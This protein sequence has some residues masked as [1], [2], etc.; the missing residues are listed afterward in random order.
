MPALLLSDGQIH[1]CPE[2]APRRECC[3]GD[4]VPFG[5]VGVCVAAN[6]HFLALLAVGVET[7]AVALGHQHHPGRGPCHGCV[8]RAF[9]RQPE[10]AEE[11]PQVLDEEIRRVR[12]GEGEAPTLAMWAIFWSTSP[13]AVRA[14]RTVK[15][16]VTPDSATESCSAEFGSEASRIR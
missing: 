5:P 1:P 14:W 9:P 6:G 15:D 16:Q 3:R 4:F 7:P 11:R 13:P 12:G 10:L 2:G 8:Q